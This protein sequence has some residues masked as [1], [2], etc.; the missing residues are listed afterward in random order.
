M[1][2]TL[3]TCVA[4]LRDRV[5][6]RPSLADLHTIEQRAVLLEAEWAPFGPRCMK[7]T[8]IKLGIITHI[9]SEYMVAVITVRNAFK[10][11]TQLVSPKTKLILA[12]PPQRRKRGSPLAVRPELP[13]A[14]HLTDNYFSHLVVVLRAP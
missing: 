13:I 12:E 6:S 4:L 3:A 10:L 11:V 1:R 7:L 14:R 9:I 2:T 5:H 8:E